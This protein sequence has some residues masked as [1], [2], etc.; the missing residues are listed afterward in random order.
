MTVPPILILS[1]SEER[2]R[3]IA[4]GNAEGDPPLLFLRWEELESRLRGLT[5]LSGVVCE[6]GGELLA[7][8]GLVEVVRRAY[9]DTPLVMFSQE[10]GEDAGRA[11]DLFDAHLTAPMSARNLR[12]LL[13][14]ARRLRNLVRRH[15]QA[16]AQVRDL[17]DKLTLL[18][19]TAKATN[20]LL[21]P[22]LVMQLLMSRLQEMVR[23][24]TWSLYLQTDSGGRSEIEVL[25]GD[26][27]GRI[28][29]S[30]HDEVGGIAAKAMR[31]RRT[32]LLD[33]AAP[34][35]ADPGTAS[36]PVGRSMLCIPLVSRGRV[37]G[38]LELSSHRGGGEGPFTERDL[39]MVRLLMEP[40][41]ITLE[42]ALLFKRLEDLSVTDDLTRLYN[43]RYLATSLSR[44]IKRARR[45]GQCVSV[46]FLDLDGFK[47][48]ND[49]HGHLA[50]S[51]ALVEVGRL[52]REVVRE[53]D[54]VSRYGGDEF[55]IVLPQ[56]APNEALI[57]ADRLRASLESHVFLTSIGV[58]V[59]I[60]ASFGISSYPAHGASHEEL[61]SH[62]DR[63]MYRV[64]ERSKNGV[65]MAPM[66]GRV[67]ATSGA[68]PA[69]GDAGGSSTKA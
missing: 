11:S 33:S 6:I 22:R 26:P 38:A 67:L 44:E 19:E 29:S 5:G 23:A 31:E 49:R 7:R 4:S 35:G 61:I 48:V 42:N 55:T 41:A 53:T 9:P 37:I 18:I 56:T 68:G 21:D 65:E 60:T 59:R 20:S 24:E 27:S 15:G 1:T 36:A 17:S 39:E 8:G 63:A 52:L 58:E 69:G 50:G 10:G 51:R 43:S 64:K 34:S 46:I 25:K 30:R 54:I 32:I 3:S 47:T 28:R 57:L 62:A 66:P 12:V 16:L 45:Y 40:A 14:G 13:E 2:A